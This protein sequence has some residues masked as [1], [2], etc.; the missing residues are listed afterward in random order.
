MQT[1]CL[2]LCDLFLHKQLILRKKTKAGSVCALVPSP[3]RSRRGYTRDAIIPA[4]Q[5]WY[6]TLDIIALLRATSI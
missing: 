6:Q 4:G 1:K 2:K 5:F 3:S